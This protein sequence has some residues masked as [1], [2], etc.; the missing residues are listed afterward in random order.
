MNISFLHLVSCCNVSNKTSHNRNVRE[1]EE[2]KYI[3][4]F[5]FKG[6]RLIRGN[7]GLS[8]IKGRP[9]SASNK[10]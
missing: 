6:D 5:D 9:R 4:I 2:Y 10:R 7:V 1:A 3:V 8:V